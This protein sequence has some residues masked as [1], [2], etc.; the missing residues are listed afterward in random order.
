MLFHQ[1]LSATLEWS[2]I[3]MLKEFVFVVIII[4]AYLTWHSTF[5]FPKSEK[6]DTK[7]IS[8]D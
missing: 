5:L 6:G 1:V 8:N 7:D 3:S 2:V 4:S